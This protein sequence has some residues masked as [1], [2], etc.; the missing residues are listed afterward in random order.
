L[1]I[2]KVI[3]VGMTCLILQLSLM[4]IAVVMLFATVLVMPPG[5]LVSVPFFADAPSGGLL[6]VI[7]DKSAAQKR[8]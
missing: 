3:A 7:G 5:I 2:D 8:E 6:G 1:R 4:L